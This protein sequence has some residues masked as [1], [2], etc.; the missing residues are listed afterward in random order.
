[1]VHFAMLLG[2]AKFASIRQE[3]FD[4]LVATAVK[5]ERDAVVEDCMLVSSERDTTEV[6]YQWFFVRAAINRDFE[7]LHGPVGG[8][9]R[10]AVGVQHGAP[11]CF[12]LI[13]Q[14]A[15]V[16]GAE[17]VRRGMEVL[18]ELGDVAQVAINGVGGVVANLHVFEHAST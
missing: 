1:M 17:A 2:S 14:G 16:L 4:E 9:H 12:M 10:G 3:P 5:A 7:A 15:D 13:R 6:D 18:G 11:A 8:M